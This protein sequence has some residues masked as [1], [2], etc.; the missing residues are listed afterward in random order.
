[1]SPQPVSL[2]LVL[3]V[4]LLSG[5]HSRRARAHRT[6]SSPRWVVAAATGTA[7]RVRGGLVLK[8][9]LRADNGRVASAPQPASAIAATASFADGSWLFA[10]VDGTLYRAPS[11]T[12]PLTVLPS[13]PFRLDPVDPVGG[14]HSRGVH[15]RGALAV[16]DAS[17]GAHAVAPDGS[18]R[19]LDLGRVLSVCFASATDAYAVSEPGVLRASHDGGRRFT[20]LRA[21]AG[22]PLSV[23]NADDDTFLRTTAGTF[24][25]ASGAFVP[26]PSAPSPSAWL[27]VP[28]SIDQGLLDAAASLP[29]PLHP[30]RA[31]ALPGGRIALIRDGAL[32]IVDARTG[33]ALSRDTLPGNDCTLHPAHRGLRAICRHQAWATLVASRDADRPGWTILRDEA[34]AEPAG[35]ATFDDASA[36][37]AVQA[38]CSQ[39]PVIDPLDVCLYDDRGVAHELRLPSP[40]TIAAV[41][42]GVALAIESDRA[43]RAPRAWLLHDG[44]ITPLRLPD[45]LRT[46]V[47]ASWSRDGLSLVHATPGAPLAL[48]FASA[49]GADASWRR[50]AVPAGF[51]RSV[52]SSDGSALF[53]GDDARSLARSR[54]GDSLSTPPSPVIGAAAALPLDPSADSYCVG[55]WCRLGGALTIAPPPTPA[56]LAIARPD[57]PPAVAPPR[58]RQR[59]IRCEHGAVTRAPEIDRGA[60]VSGHAVSWSLEGSMLSVTWS[61]ETSQGAVARAVTVRPGARPSGRGVQGTRTPA[62][63]IELCAPSGCDHLLALPSGY[64]E[65]GLGRARPGGVEVQQRPG[66]FV[67]RADD[68]RD[69]V[70]L[71][72]VVA[73]DPAGVITARRTFALAAANDEAHLGS[74]SGRDGLWI[75]DREGRARF[76][77]LDPADTGG[78]ALVTAPGPDASTRGCASSDAPGEMRRMERVAQVSGPG[79]FVEGGEWQTEEVIALGPTGACVRS[80]TGG[81]ARDEREASGG[82]EERE[83]VRSFVLRA[84]GEGTFEGRAWSGDRAIALRCR[85]E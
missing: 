48:S 43:E 75:D 14:L 60:A 16:L 30:G 73:L 82:R 68:A 74:W 77:A 45:D 49:P 85:M 6:P 59:A 29:V 25:L 56:A 4:A 55:P 7:V 38:P 62:G 19:P 31:A 39:R 22:V 18:H 32:Q 69:G 63:L 28:R 36:A 37:W 12:G 81:E 42:R 20:V 61:G 66:G 78:E 54:R 84:T 80:I 71:V 35:A 50:V 53:F 3:G 72:T 79:W 9:S 1:M 26:D 52:F 76:L 40:A 41:H 51:T 58:S 5:C 8:G 27:G 46:P 15:S 67:A 34:R 65:L 44:A 13:L 70:T 10:S 23:W 33:R 83:P 17:L 21:P 11:F 47:S 24:R 64:T 57:A 2:S